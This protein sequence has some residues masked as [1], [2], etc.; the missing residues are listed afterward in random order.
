MDRLAHRSGVTDRE[1]AAALP[2]DGLL[3]DATD[4]I[5]RAVTLPAPPEQ[6]WPW[7]VQLGKGRG[8][9]YF[10]RWVERAVPPSRRGLRRIEPSLQGVAVGDDHADWGP[11]APVL[12]VAEIDPARAL[13]FLSLRDKAAGH[14]WPAD[15]RAER[16]GVFA[17][18]WA[19]VLTPSGERG[20]RLHL[21]LR[22]RA[23]SSL[24][25][26]VGGLFDWATVVLL[27]AGL[28]ERL[29]A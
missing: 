3:P 27:F 7:L 13:V 25:T 4:V 12:R 15:G 26:A 19:L 20:T 18:S 17:M 22:L 14:R 16:P 1:V 6:V 10:P 28:R 23:H 24:L 8:G 9:W 21:R 2:G 11:G 5:D 29:R